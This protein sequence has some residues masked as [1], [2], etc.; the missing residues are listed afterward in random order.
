MLTQTDLFV[1]EYKKFTLLAGLTDEK[2]K[3]RYLHD[4]DGKQI[5]RKR[6]CLLLGCEANDISSPDDHLTTAGGEGLMNSTFML[7]I[8]FIVI[9]VILLIILIFFVSLNHALNHPNLFRMF[10]GYRNKYYSQPKSR[11]AWSGKRKGR[12]KFSIKVKK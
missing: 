8:V 7:T 11:D 3:I 10:T 4:L 2:H 1:F 5:K 12:F 6:N 9:L